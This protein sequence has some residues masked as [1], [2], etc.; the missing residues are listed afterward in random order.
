MAATAVHLA[1]LDGVPP[2]EPK[3]PEAVKVRA[4][5]LVADLVEPAKVDA[6]EKVGEGRPAFDIANAWLRSKLAQESL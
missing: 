4:S 3:D 2:S 6:L 5:E 1:E